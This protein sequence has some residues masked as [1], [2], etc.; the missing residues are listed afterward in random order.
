M[1]VQPNQFTLKGNHVTFAFLPGNA[2]RRA[3]VTYTD[4]S[5]TKQFAG[6]AVRVENVAIGTLVTVSL[7]LTIDTGGVEFSVLLPN[8]QLANASSH[9]AFT[10]DGIRTAFKGPNSIPHT[11]SETYEFIHMT[12]T[13]ESVAVPQG[14][15]AKSA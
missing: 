7:E 3:A 10:T 2:G 13:A 12:G 9:Q 1:S 14:A 6:S 4:P 11:V 15:A 8:I 5:G